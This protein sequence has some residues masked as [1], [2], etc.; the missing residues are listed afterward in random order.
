MIIHNKEK[1]IEANAFMAEASKSDFNEIVEVYNSMYKKTNVFIAYE[2][3]GSEHI[4]KY[5]SKIFE[6]FSAIIYKTFKNYKINLFITPSGYSADGVTLDYTDQFK[7]I[8]VGINMRK[9]S[10]I[11]RLRHIEIIIAHEMVH[12]YFC[13]YRRVHGPDDKYKQLLKEVKEL[14]KKDNG[15]VAKVCEEL[16]K[17]LPAHYTDYLVDEEIL[18]NVIAW[19]HLN[20]KLCNK[21]L[22]LFDR[23]RDDGLS[24]TI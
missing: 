10:E 7:C 6:Y 19:K 1:E 23:F 24:W 22:C 4:L 15:D 11:D 9:I 13:A 17:K 5:V 16:E 8:D 14:V 2:I 20:K 21:C 3:V 12:A 18:C